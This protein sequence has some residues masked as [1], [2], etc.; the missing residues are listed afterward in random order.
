MGYSRN[1]NSMLTT[2]GVRTYWYQPGTVCDPQWDMIER[3]IYFGPDSLF[4]WYKIMYENDTL[5]LSEG[6][7]W[8]WEIDYHSYEL[9]ED[10]LFIKQWGSEPKTYEAYKILYITEQKLVLLYLTKDS[11]SQWVEYREPPCDQLIILEFDC[12]KKKNK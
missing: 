6:L 12:S 1:Y 3:G 8:S 11:L 7:E 2:P 4:D 10:T 9:R 5:S